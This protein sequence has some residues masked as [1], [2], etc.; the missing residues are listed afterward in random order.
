MDEFRYG[1]PRNCE[2]CTGVKP[3]NPKVRPYLQ[4]AEGRRVMLIGQD[5]TVRRNPERVERVL[6]LDKESGQLSRWLRD[7]FEESSWQSLNL[8]ATNLVK[9][10][11]DRPVPT[12]GRLGRD[13]LKSRF[14]EC[15]KYLA[16]EIRLFEPGLVVTLGGRSHQFFA[17]MMDNADEISLV[18]KTAFTG[19]L[20]EASFEG[21]EFLYSPCLHITTF[22]VAETYGDKVAD[23]KKGIRNYLQGR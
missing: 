12:T 2:N 7:L 9:C 16:R 1:Y 14:H 11:F 19:E 5:P 10:G 22:R 6:M 20:V 18:M 23:F 13:M 8:Y 21:L 3:G 4:E 15:K 17:T